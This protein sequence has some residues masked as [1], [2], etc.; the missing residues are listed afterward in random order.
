MCGGGNGSL[1]GGVG[2]CEYRA[3]ECH[4]FLLHPVG[5]HSTE[6]CALTPKIK[7]MNAHKTTR[8]NVYRP[9]HAVHTHHKHMDTVPTQHP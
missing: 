5:C 2:G 6:L 9:E 7:Q 8:S 4:L 3:H 1:K